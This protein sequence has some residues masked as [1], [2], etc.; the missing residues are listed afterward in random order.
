V[1][2]DLAKD[3]K[4]ERNLLVHE[5]TTSIAPAELQPDW[6]TLAELAGVLGLKAE[7]I[8]EEST[9]G[10]LSDAEIEALLEERQ[11]ARKAK[12]FA[13][14]DRI[15]NLLQEQGITLIDQ[16]GGTRWHRG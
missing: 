15:R 7:L 16:A 12:N 1:L 9:A 14:A 13:E 3:L 10:G 4:R 8:A 5:G 2:F 11:A 6:Q